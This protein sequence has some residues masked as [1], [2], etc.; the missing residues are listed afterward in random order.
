METSDK[1]KDRIKKLLAQATSNNEHESAAALGMAQELLAKHRLSMAD[2]PDNEVPHEDVV[3]DNDPLF[4]AGRIHTW[5]SQLANIFATFNNCRLVKYTGAATGNN[6]RGSKLVIF[7]RPSDID[8]VRYL[9]AYSITTLTN[10]ARIPCMDEGHSYKQSWFLGAVNGIHTKLKEGKIRAQE[11]ASKFALVKV[12][13]QLKEVDDFIRS[14][15]GKLRKGTGG[16]TKINY[17]AYAQGERAGRNL[18]LGDAKRLGKKNT[19]GIR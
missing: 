16:N 15:V 3:C 5:K 13:N 18:D 4:A 9:L 8:M 2:L 12:E 14:N 17:D 1:I 7:G 11:G 19:L 10:F 6:S